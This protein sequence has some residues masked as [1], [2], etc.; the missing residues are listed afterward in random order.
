M[1]VRCNFES[2]LNVCEASVLLRE[3][4]RT[5]PFSGE[6]VVVAD[7]MD[8]PRSRR[9]IDDVSSALSGDRIGDVRVEVRSCGSDE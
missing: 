7:V 3:R 1:S 8:V 6:I 9:W 5:A 4:V 2:E